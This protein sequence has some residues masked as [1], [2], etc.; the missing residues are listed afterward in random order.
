MCVHH[1]S[2]RCFCWSVPFFTS[3]T[4]AQLSMLGSCWIIAIPLYFL[5]LLLEGGKSFTAA[6]KTGF[7]AFSGS[8]HCWGGCSVH[9]EKGEHVNSMIR[10]SIHCSASCVAQMEKNTELIYLSKSRE[11]FIA[12]L[13]EN[14][15]ITRLFSSAL[16]PPDDLNGLIFQATV[17]PYLGLIA[18]QMMGLFAYLWTKHR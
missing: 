8:R 7:V 4:L 18:C 17:G 5:E 2:S 3:K 13:L 10:F 12:S 15:F 6:T 11:L 14:F 16:L 1:P 9:F